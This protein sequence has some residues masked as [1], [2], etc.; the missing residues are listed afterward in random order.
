MAIDGPGM[1]DSDPGYDIYNLILDLYDAGVD[2]TDILDQFNGHR[3]S[4][5]GPLFCE[6]HLT[7]GAQA[8]WE[9]GLL[10][11]QLIS[12]VRFVIENGHGLTDWRENIGDDTV[13]KK[14]LKSFLKKISIPKKKPRP[15]KRYSKVARKLYACGDCV[16]LRHGKYLF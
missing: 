5:D 9:I 7:A 3:Y 2:A 11:N 13:R 8:L 12:E 15:R 14:V 1:V 4:L 10:N 6:I 16:T